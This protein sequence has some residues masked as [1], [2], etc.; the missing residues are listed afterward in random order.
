ME[1]K[2]T[3]EKIEVIEKAF[4]EE[5]RLTL[6]RIYY[7]LLSK[8]MIT[9]SKGSYVNLSK[10]LTK[11]RESG[12]L[13]SDM[14]VDSHRDLIKSQT[15][16]DFDEAFDQLCKGYYK[17][18]MELQK[19]YVEVWIEKDT[20]THIFRGY[21]LGNDVP[22]VVSKGFTSYSFKQEA[23]ERYKQ[24]EKPITILYFGD[25]DPEGEHI[26][27]ILKDFFNRHGIEFTFKKI[28][29]RPEDTGGIPSLPLE[30]KPKQ[31]EKQYVKDFIRKF[32]RVKY[33]IEA[34]SFAEQKRRFMEALDNEIDLQVVKSI[35]E[36]SKKE[37]EDWKK[38]HLK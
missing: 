33:E 26:P 38:E 23:V 19:Q 5:G 30:L 16:K 6:R 31:M 25:L 32:G 3:L 18:S 20:M 7:I 13:D 29:V 11:L 4:K 24:I 17:D 27:N 22:L 37:V 15:Y 14:I 34:L 10:L 1:T 2:K 12:S 28:M 8:G 36:E 21:C 9:H 35:E